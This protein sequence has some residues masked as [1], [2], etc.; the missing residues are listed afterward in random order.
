MHRDHSGEFVCGY[1]CLKGWNK[2]LKH[3][4]RAYLGLS[5]VNCQ[6]LFTAQLPPPL[7]RWDT[8]PPQHCSS[9]WYVASLKKKTKLKTCEK[10]G[11]GRNGFLTKIKTQKNY[12]V[13]KIY[14]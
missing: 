6:E 10:R 3:T 4:A 8:S 11:K 13:S 5:T 7:P 14:I 9:Q 2:P 1:W 12:V